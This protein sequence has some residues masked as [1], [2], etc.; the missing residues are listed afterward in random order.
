MRRVLEY[1]ENN[2]IYMIVLAGVMI[3]QH[4]SESL[5]KR[6][7]GGKKSKRKN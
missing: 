4:L 1:T 7:T 2:L 5:Q 3:L 6:K